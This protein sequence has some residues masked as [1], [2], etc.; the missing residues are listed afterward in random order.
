MKKRFLFT[1][2]ITTF[3]FHASAQIGWFEQNSGVTNTLNSAFFTSTDNGFIVGRMG[4]I[5]KTTNGGNV[6]DTLPS[7]SGN[8]HINEIFFTDAS[9]G[10]YL[11]GIQIQKTT[12]A[13]A[14]WSYQFSTTGGSSIFFPST[15]IGF[16]AG[17]Y[18]TI[19]K[20][21]TG[22][23]WTMQ[24]PPTTNHLKSI[25]FT[26]NDVGVA[27]GDNGTI[28]RTIN[29]GA[30]WDTISS[31]TSYSLKS[32]FFTDANT[33]YIVGSEIGTLNGV[34]LKSIDAGII[35]T[36]SYVNYE[37]NSVYFPSAN[38]GYAVGYDGATAGGCIVKTTDAGTSWNKQ[39][40]TTNQTLLSVFFTSDDV[41]Y[42]VGTSGKI[43]KT[44][45]GGVTYP[46]FEE[47]ICKNAIQINNF[48]NP[49]NSSTTIEYTLF[50]KADINITIYNIIGEEIITLVNE[51]QNIGRHYIIWDGANDAGE[52]VKPGVYYYRLQTGNTVITKS[53][54]YS[55]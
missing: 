45:N 12:D 15:S 8:A 29:S 40:S 32:V 28:I 5:L 54:L 55:K 7:A 22:I 4:R 46:G 39:V 53:M 35:W 27:V 2:F 37:L 49:F 13:G 16:V 3:L 24:I 19:L 20:T 17:D 41:G 11:T 43:L 44:T 51:I 21:I 47:L 9:T 48:P 30:T 31:G 23:N 10:Y 34:I 25:F 50:E 52:I 18:G 26:S 1:L 33:G 14:S 42:A 6:W 38:V 36:P